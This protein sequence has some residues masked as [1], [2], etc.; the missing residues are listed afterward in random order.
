VS[1]HSTHTWRRC[2]GVITK[3]WRRY[4]DGFEFVYGLWEFRPEWFS[5][6][7]RDIGPPFFKPFSH[8][9]IPDFTATTGDPGHPVDEG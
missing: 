4:F 2:I 5:N 3:M 7:E 9:Q 6:V 1:Q 8:L